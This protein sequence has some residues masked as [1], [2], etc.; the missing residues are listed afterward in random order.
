MQGSTSKVEA[1]FVVTRTFQP[2]RYSLSLLC[3]AY[4]CLVSNSST[5]VPQEVTGRDTQYLS[6]AI[7]EAE[8]CLPV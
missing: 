1:R 2:T 6:T 4:E 7:Q 5:N 3:E 8:P